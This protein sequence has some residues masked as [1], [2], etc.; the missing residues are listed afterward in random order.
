MFFIKS[1]SSSSSTSGSSGAVGGDGGD[2]LDS[3][4]F[5]SE[6]CKGSEG[7]LCSGS[8]CFW[9]HSSTGSQFNVQAVDFQFFATGHHVVGSQ[10]SYLRLFCE[11][12]VYKLLALRR[13]KLQKKQI[14]YQHRGKILLYRLS[15]SYLRSLCRGFLCLKDLW[16][17]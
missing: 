15:L 12:R 8:W 10:H 4:D 3:S 17:G 14:Y 5:H 1:K 9:L 13:N 16:C 7:G 11:R 2:V 6:T